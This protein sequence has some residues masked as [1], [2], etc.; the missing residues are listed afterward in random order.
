MYLSR[1]HRELSRGLASSSLCRVLYL[2]ALSLPT[3]R[4]RAASLAAVLPA[5]R[6][7]ELGAR[8]SQASSMPLCHVSGCSAPSIS[9]TDMLPP[10]LG[11]VTDTSEDASRYR[12]KVE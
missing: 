6:S 12:E 11:R 4:T 5:I 3:P 1:S 7:P 8:S 2:E 10:P 9:S